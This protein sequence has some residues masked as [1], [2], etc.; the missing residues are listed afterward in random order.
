MHIYIWTLAVILT[1]LSSAAHPLPALL[2]KPA[3]LQETGGQDWDCE[4]EGH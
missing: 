2:R 1:L 4:Q 3:V